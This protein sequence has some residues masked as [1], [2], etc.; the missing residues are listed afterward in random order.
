MGLLAT[1][2]AGLIAGGLYFGVA[3]VADKRRR[4]GGR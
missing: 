1:A 3:V 4:E 2:G